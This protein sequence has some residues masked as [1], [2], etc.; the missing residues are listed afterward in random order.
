MMLPPASKTVPS[1]VLFCSFDV[2]TDLST[3]GKQLNEE[4][5]YGLLRVDWT[6]DR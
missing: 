4:I 1:P 2:V 3:L 6:V 5:H